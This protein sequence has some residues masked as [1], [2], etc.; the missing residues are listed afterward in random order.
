MSLCIHRHVCVFADLLVLNV[1]ICWWIPTCTCTSVYPTGSTHVCMQLCVYLSVNTYVYSTWVCTV[2]LFVYNYVCTCV[3]LR[4]QFIGV[5]TPQSLTGSIHVF[6]YLCVYI[7]VV[8]PD[9]TCVFVH[10]PYLSVWLTYCICVCTSVNLYVCVYVSPWVWAYKLIYL[11]YR[12]YMCMHFCVNT[13]LYLNMHTPVYLYTYF[14]VYTHVYSKNTAL[15]RWMCIQYILVC[16]CMPTVCI[17][18]QCYAMN[19][20]KY[21]CCCMFPYLPVCVW[22]EQREKEE[23]GSSLVLTRVEEQF[24]HWGIFDKSHTELVQQED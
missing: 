24:Q 4:I 8:V 6:M 22:Y 9:C 15:Y 2:Y 14:F 1:S 10:V 12:Y 5:C 21:L 19:A 17:P 16:V 18:L 13:C 20:H 3:Y 11:L 7:F 23:V